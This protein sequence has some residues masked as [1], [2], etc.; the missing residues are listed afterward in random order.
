M[1]IKCVQS[2]HF[3]ELKEELPCKKALIHIDFSENFTH[4]IQDEIQSA[5]W[6]TP[7]STLYTA[8]A[9]YR[10]AQTT[11]EADPQCS[12]LLSI[13]YV[14]V[15]DYKHNDKYAVAVFNDLIQT[16]LE[17]EYGPIDSIEYQ[18]DGAAQHFK[19]KFSLCY[20]TLNRKPTKWYFSDTSHRKGCIDGIGGTIKRR[21]AEAV[22]ASQHD[23]GTSQ[24]FADIAVKVCPNINILYAAKEKVENAKPGLDSLW[25][26][27]DSNLQTL[28]GIRE[29]HYF[30][31]LRPYVLRCQPT[32]K[33]VTSSKT[34]SFVDGKVQDAGQVD[35][36]TPA[37]TSYTVGQWVNVIYESQSYCGLILDEQN[38]HYRIRCLLK[39]EQSKGYRFEAER[40]AIWYERSAIVSQMSHVPNLLNARGLYSV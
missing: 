33:N 30:E 12:P 29:Y 11:D 23:M 5:Y 21:V 9:Y 26:P 1:H 10:K 18:S 27:N 22:R 28:A 24:N 32:S 8:M 3:K 35:T 13:P 17:T 38:H 2:A 36:T 19:Q 40:D 14:I 7:S 6:D 37:M 15:S 25:T 16:H 31:S 34:F 4:T 39:M 20:M